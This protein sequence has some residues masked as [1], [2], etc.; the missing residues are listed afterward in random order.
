LA[1]A[2]DE[3][4]EVKRIYLVD[5]QKARAE[6]VAAEL[7]KAIV[8]DSVEDELY[9]CDLVIEAATQSA[10]KEILSKVVS[11]GVD[12]MV[13]SVGSLV[14]DDFRKTVFDKAVVSEAKI[15]LPTGGLCGLDALRAAVQGEVS[16]V[17]LITTKGPHALSGVQYLTDKGID[18]DA[19]KEKTTV[20][21]GTAREAVKIFPRNVNVAATVAL[22]GIGF[23]RT[24]VTIVLDPA[25]TGNSYDL[26]AAGVFGHFDAH[27]YNVPEPENAKNS[28]LAV[29]SAVAALKR[30]C[31][32]EWFG[33]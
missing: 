24:K 25:E 26:Q 27:T 14:D 32:N 30:I 16:S 31:R 28:H 29:L 6:K 4:N 22:M 17:E 3:M 21:S 20:F 11:R 8:V 23:D 9:H 12:I 2:A 7:K 18:V 1:R 13:M 19:I 15:F 10:A 33:I 5:Q